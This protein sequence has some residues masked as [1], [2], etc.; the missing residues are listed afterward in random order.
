[1]RAGAELCRAALEKDRQRRCRARVVD[2][3]KQ[4][5]REHIW[6]VLDSG[7]AALDQATQGHIPNFKGS[8]SAADRLG[9]LP[10]WQNARTIKAV[11]DKFSL[12]RSIWTGSPSR[13]CWVRIQLGEIA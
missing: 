11:P 4:Q 2:D 10:A 5:V 13:S 7:G 1:M 6:D 8:Q 12:P 3:A 9:A